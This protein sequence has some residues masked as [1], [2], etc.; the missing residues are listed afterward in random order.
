[1]RELVKDVEFI[2]PAFLTGGNQNEAMLRPAAV[3]GELRWWFRVLG[4][5]S[6][7]ELSVFGGVQPKAQASKVIVRIENERP[8]HEQ[9]V[10]PAPMSDYGY[11]A[12]FAT[13]SGERKGVRVEQNAYFAPG[14]TF[15]IRIIE[16]RVL[17]DSEYMR[18]S[19]AF[20]CLARLGALGLRAT[21][22]FGAMKESHEMSKA[23]F[24][25]WIKTLP[26]KICVRIASDA[27]EIS[28]KVAQS[29][30]GGF[31]R[32]I[33]RD[34]K[35]NGNRDKSAFGYSLKMER[36]SSALRLRPVKIK[37]GFLPVCVY[38]DMACCE[39]SREEVVIRKSFSV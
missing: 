2:T 9:F 25:N 16:R 36:A 6:E 34:T 7:E 10:K 15:T 39:A 12:Y 24:S 26:S 17:N 38:T 23:E 35:A 31:L 8:K 4:G 28:A 13:V 3:R 33:R 1:M 18:L 29:V 32:D 37:E 27:V 14:T 19:A 22:T 5:T 30:L 20:D 21:R 11:L